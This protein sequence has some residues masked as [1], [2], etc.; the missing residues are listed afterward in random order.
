MIVTAIGNTPVTAQPGGAPVFA[1]ETGRFV[2]EIPLEE[3][4][5][6]TA[7]GLGSDI[8][9]VGLPDLASS[10]AAPG[11]VRHA[12]VSSPC[13]RVDLAEPWATLDLGDIVAFIGA[14]QT[15]QLPADIAPPW[16]VYD[17]SD[18]TAFVHQFM[19]GCP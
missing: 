5:T 7:I 10:I 1:V 16:G 18:I 4:A 6:P 3:N 9:M 2:G 14:M 8:A 17:L 11:L 15:Q 13:A 19:L 12:D